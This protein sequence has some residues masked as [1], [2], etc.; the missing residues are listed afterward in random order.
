MGIIFDRVQ[1]L[2]YNGG[3]A[4]IQTLLAQLQDKG[5]TVAAIADELGMARHSVAGWKA[6][7][8]RPANVRAV[9]IVL[10]QLAKRRRVP[11]QR[12]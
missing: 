9:E 3:M 8:H 5:W 12:R 10:E 11:K 1:T 6:G 4:E 2:Y 7:N